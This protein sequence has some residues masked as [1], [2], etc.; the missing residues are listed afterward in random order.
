MDEPAEQNDPH[1]VSAPDDPPAG[2]EVPMAARQKLA[3]DAASLS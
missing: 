1:G 3:A 2:A